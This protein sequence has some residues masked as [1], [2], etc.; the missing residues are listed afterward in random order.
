MNDYPVIKG[1]RILGTKKPDK[2]LSYGYL[3]LNADAASAHEALRK[4]VRENGS[5]CA[6]RE[7]EFAGDTL[8]SDR[9]A[10]LECAGCP[11]YSECEFFR[12]VAH[13]GWGT[14]AGV[15]KGR[16]IMEEVEDDFE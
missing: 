15:V 4:S 14:W 7:D 11:S 16:G 6:G 3:Q 9:E 5:N 13:P 2:Q 10:M 12:Q 1:Y 8:M